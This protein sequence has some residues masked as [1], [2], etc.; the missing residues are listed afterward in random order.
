LRSRGCR[1][2]RRR[3]AS[4]C[5]A[6]GSPA[7]ARSE[8]G[9]VAPSCIGA[10]RARRL[11]SAMRARWPSSSRVENHASSSN[12]SSA[13]VRSSAA[14]ARAPRELGVLG[15]HRLVQGDGRAEGLANDAFDGVLERHVEEH[16]SGIAPICS[17][18]GVAPKRAARFAIA[19]AC[20]TSSIAAARPLGEALRR[21]QGT[22][23]ACQALERVH[24]ER[25]ELGA[26]CEVVAHRGPPPSRTRGT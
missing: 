9:G 5:V 19:L 22:E 14:M 1:R 10:L 12:A 24:G 21:T 18:G 20:E 7:S 13:C 26:T 8:E 11:R 17:A 25:L 15:V 16:R 2:A 3:M 4:A 23:L 6:G